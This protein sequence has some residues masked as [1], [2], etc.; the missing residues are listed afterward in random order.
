MSE[1]TTSPAAT[2]MR[3]PAGRKIVSERAR[4]ERRL[5]LMLV[6]PAAIIMIAVTGYPIIYASARDN[7]APIFENIAWAPWPRVDENTPSR[8]PIG[9]FNWGVGANTNHPREAFEA[10]ACMRNEEN[11]REMALKGGLPPTL[12]SLYDDPAFKK[13]YPFAD[14]IRSSLDNAAVRPRTP[15]YSDV[16]QVIFTVLHPPASVRPE[17]AGELRNMIEEALK[18]EALL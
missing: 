7:K 6:A 3:R 9:G 15:V 10:A 16:A 14:A 18:G 5:G 12:E 17:K 2:T 1:T 8:A 4:A 11:Q 13:D